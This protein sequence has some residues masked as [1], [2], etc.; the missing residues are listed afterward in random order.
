MQRTAHWQRQRPSPRI[1]KKNVK[2]RI[3]AAAL[4]AHTQCSYSCTFDLWRVRLVVRTQPSQGW[5]TGSTPV[6]AAKQMLILFVRELIVRNR[7]K[8]ESG[9]ISSSDRE[10]RDL[11]S[12]IANEARVSTYPAKSICPKWVDTLLR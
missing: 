10:G 9:R 11:R 5:C 6:R 12:E 2:N 1:N 3:C 7:Q 4:P 8:G